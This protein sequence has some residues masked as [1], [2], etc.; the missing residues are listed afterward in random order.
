[1]TAGLE[2]K[3][4]LGL[5]SA[6]YNRSLLNRPHTF[7]EH[8]LFH[9]YTAHIFTCD[10]LIP[11]IIPWTISGVVDALHGGLFTSPSSADMLS[12]APRVPYAVLWLWLNTLAFAITNQMA[13]RSVIEDRINKPWRAI[14]SG[15]ITRS[16]A[17][18][19]LLGLVPTVFVITT[20]LGAG[21][22]T[23]MALI[24]NWMYNDLGGSD[25]HYVVRNMINALAMV[26]SNLGTT[27]VAIHGGQ[28]TLLGYKWLTIKAAIIF[29]TLQVQ[30][31]RD[32]EGDRTRRRSTVPIVLGDRFARWSIAVPIMAWSLLAPYF[33]VLG[34]GGFVLPVSFGF[35]MGS[36]VL[37]QR[38]VSADKLDQ[39]GGMIAGEA[40]CARAEGSGGGFMGRARHEFPPG[41]SPAKDIEEARTTTTEL[42]GR[43]YLM[44]TLKF[45]RS[46]WLPDQVQ[47]ATTA[48]LPAGLGLVSS[49][50]R[51]GA[52]VQSARN[53]QD[54][55]ARIE[56]KFCKGDPT[57]AGK[58]CHGDAYAGWSLWLWFNIDERA[59]SK[60]TPDAH[61]ILSD[62]TL[63]DQNRLGTVHG[64][65]I[66]SMV[67]LAGSLAVA[68]NGLFA[69]GVSTDLGVTFLNPGGRVGDTLRAEATCDKFGKTLA[70]TSIRFMNGTNE[71][72]ARGSHTK[73][74]A[75]A[76]KDH[77]N[78]G[79][80][81]NAV[82]E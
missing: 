15:R 5:N 16:Q 12:I 30:D 71:L 25:V 26:V 18:N 34:A 64:G 47:A 27:Q 17:R 63:P 56:L 73:Y 20:Y 3:T 10:Y 36:R 80:E 38:N 75:S 66:A 14:P 81:M 67:D 33:W 57:S 6:G 9:I 60:V 52:K 8:F 35:L 69:T 49:K 7:I 22:T 61:K 51:T 70:Y 82:T 50:F 41:Y 53:K 62:N 42:L 59:Y 58:A 43:V 46:V 11:T 32:H 77:N 45:V 1:M 2:L 13:S 68:S 72:V 29:T 48:D 28:L 44:A 19:L 39:N 79:E 78:Q 40:S 55:K 37:L 65:T 4:I 74:I 24:L 23:L 31:L 76:W 21:T 54:H